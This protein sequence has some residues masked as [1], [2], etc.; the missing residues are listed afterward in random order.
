MG[1]QQRLRVTAEAEIGVDDDRVRPGQRGSEQ[2]QNAT[3]HD[4]NVTTRLPRVLRQRPPPP[5][6]SG[7]FISSGQVPIRIAGPDI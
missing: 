7:P 2:L 3:D 1:R 6:S 4:R 5:I